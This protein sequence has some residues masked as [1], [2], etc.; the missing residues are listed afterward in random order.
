MLSMARTADGGL[1][2][3]EVP[4]PE[5][6]P[7]EVLIGASVVGLNPVDRK[8][9]AGRGMASEYDP[10][11]PMVVGWDVVGVVEQVGEGVTRLQRGDRVFGM[12]SFPWPARAYSEYVVAQS[13]QV[14][15]V[16]DELSDL[17][18]APLCLSALTAWQAIV[19]TLR[20]GDGE[21]I[22]IHAAAGGVGHV[23]V[24]LAASRGAEVWATA[25]E[26]HHDGLRELG[27][28]HAIDYRNERFEDAAQGMDA[29]LDL[30]GLHDYPMRS[31]DCLRRGGRLVVI[32]NPDQVPAPAIL[33]ERDVTATWML[34]E[35]DYPALER[36]GRMA[37]AGELKPIVA[38]HRPLRRIEELYELADAGAPLGKLA[39][40]VRED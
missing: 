37:A 22:L 9:L 32:P 4:V 24:Q 10:E 3:I 34:V 21:R 20:I 39:A 25:S 5:P 33:E 38:A 28:A 6:G 36:L 1:E 27:T 18:A 11:E 8:T 19:D 13:R 30:V 29:V 14:A 35:P 17:D 12:P 40:T 26:R 2:P 16:P 15:I 7:T 23:A 31:L